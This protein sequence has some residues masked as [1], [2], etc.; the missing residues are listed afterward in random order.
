MEK[1]RKNETTEAAPAE[2]VKKPAKR[3]SSRKRRRRA[4]KIGFVV[5]LSVLL[6]LV[7]GAAIAAVIV[8][9][10]IQESGK[11]MP[12]VYVGE[13]NVGELTKEEV[14]KALL[15][16]GWDEQNGGTLTVTLPADIDF[17]LDYYEAGVSITAEQM[18]EAAY[19]YGHG[20]KIG[21]A[22]CRESG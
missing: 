14:E 20:G 7:V 19:A 15:D 13:L 3:R 10:N 8:G 22:S 21:R 16:S 6:I 11:T 12:N 5:T 2:P 1:E 4:A 18:A 9:H 17:T